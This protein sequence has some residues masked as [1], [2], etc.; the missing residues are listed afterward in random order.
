MTSHTIEPD[1]TTAYEE[2]R[3]LSHL[4]LYGRKLATRKN[5]PAIVV[6]FALELLVR[7]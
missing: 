7:H 5:P 6:G 4:K 1:V 3:R 2:K